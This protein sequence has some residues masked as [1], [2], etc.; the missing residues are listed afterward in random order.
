MQKMQERI[1]ERLIQIRGRI[2]AACARAGRD[3]EQVQ[4]IAVTKYTTLEVAE[5]VLAAGLNHIGE[6]RWQDVRPKWEAIGERAVWHFIGSLQT[7]KVKDVIGKFLY[8]H[9]LDRLSLAEELNRKAAALSLPPVNCLVQVNISGEESKHG[10]PL[11][12]AEAFIAAVGQLPFIRIAGL[13][14]MAPM[15]GDAEAARPVF[16]GLREL[17]DQLNEKQI[18]PYELKE[19][20][21]GMSGDFETAVEEGATFVRLGTVLV[22]QDPG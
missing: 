13:M 3:S 12:E 16:R 10:L 5:A 14:T 4:I 2:E 21:M 1:E 18:L 17:R 15:D 7:N 11:A 20:S 22:G 19:L 6:N 9:S 8:I